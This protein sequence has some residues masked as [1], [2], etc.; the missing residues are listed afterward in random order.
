MIVGIMKIYP[1]V[2]FLAT[3]FMQLC[4]LFL[5][6]LL[7]EV[8]IL[9]IKLSHQNL[10]CA[11]II[12]STNGELV[13]WIIWF[14]LY[15]LHDGCDFQWRSQN[16]EK[17][18]TSKGNYWIII[19]DSLHL[20]LISKWEIPRGSKFFLKEQFLMAWRITFTTLSDLPWLLLFLLG[21]C[22]SA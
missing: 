19:S 17:L 6:I 11:A 15:G 16:A 5:L 21:A 20:R 9:L 13:R 12:A 14:Q 22:V 8:L 4:I 18:C 7:Q 3:I 2:L 1:F 10:A